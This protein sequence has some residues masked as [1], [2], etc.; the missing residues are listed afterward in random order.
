MA[1]PTDSSST[2][3]T[4]HLGSSD[5]FS[6]LPSKPRLG[7]PGPFVINL[8]ASTAP[9]GLPKGA[10]IGNVGGH[11]YQIQ[12]VEDHRLRYRL[13]LGPFALEE[14]ADCVLAKV[15]DFY[16]AALTATADA[17]DQ[18]ALS[19]IVKAELTKSAAASARASA[20]PEKPVHP[21]PSREMVAL[22]AP[23]RTA[24]AVA[25]DSTETRRTFGNAAATANPPAD[26]SRPA[27][28]MPT[29]ATGAPAPAAIPVVSQVVESSHR[30]AL[31]SR[32]GAKDTV[33]ANDRVR[34]VDTT[35]TVRALTTAEIN[36]EAALRSFIIELAQSAEP[37]DPKEVPHLDIF[38]AYRLYSVA[39]IEQGKI[40]HSLRLGFF[41]EETAAIA[42]SSYL[43]AFYDQPV[44]RRVSLAERDRFAHQRLEAQKDV[45]ATGKHASIEITNE[46][47]VRERRSQ[48]RGQ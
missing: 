18:R 48:V 36:D 6:S 21:A 45:G 31:Q 13:R 27:A 17:D 5:G 25:L 37:F 10:D 12:R 38:G 1:T 44:I 46:R 39:S 16:P 30:A 43:G 14:E 23:V 34:E 8:S 11:I 19:H 47:Y 33:S 26:I 42:V 40:V 28:V 15:R 35:R 29:V 24:T 9:I 3:E 4:W 32:S 7:G 2:A 22:A 41:G 20:T